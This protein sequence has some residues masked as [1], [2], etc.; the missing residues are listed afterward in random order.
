MKI[1]EVLKI[2]SY[3]LKAKIKSSR[4]Y[5]QNGRNYKLAKKYLDKEK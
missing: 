3:I 5:D 1:L 2:N 4:L